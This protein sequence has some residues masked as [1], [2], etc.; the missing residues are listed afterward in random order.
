MTTINETSAMSRARDASVAWWTVAILTLAQILSFIDRMVVAI[1]VDPIRAD[2]HLSDIQIG[3]LQGLAFALFYGVMGIPLG[4]M[5]DTAN[6]R[7]LITAGIL[8][9]SVATMCCGLA[10]SFAALFIARVL[11]GVGEAS[12]SP[13]AYSM[14]SD[15]FAKER[16]SRAIGV[17]SAGSVVGGGAA[18]VVGGAVFAALE[19]AGGMTLPLVGH[20]SAWQ[21]TFV[22]VGAPGLIVAA[23]VFLSTTE[24]PR[25]GLVQDK[26]SAGLVA[27]HLTKNGAL[28]AGI[29]GCHV[30][31]AAA[32]YGL[33]NWTPTVLVRE[34]GLPAGDAGKTFGAIMLTAGLAGPVIGGW[35][36]D[37]RIRRG[38]HGGPIKLMLLGFALLAPLGLAFLFVS[39]KTLFLALLGGYVLV[40][41]A[42]VP[43]T[44]VMVQLL[45]PNRMRGQIAAINMM[46]GIIGGLGVAPVAVPVVARV[47]FGGEIQPAMAAVIAF[48]CIGGVLCALLTVGR[49]GRGAQP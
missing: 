27:A 47:A 40:C 49:A 35:L 5:A 21:A 29:F 45:A 22:A 24:P 42:L 12:L 23:I 2:L 14:F 37:H 16:L 36:S 39:G 43:L 15:L 8:L 46:I 25:S 44:H 19:R 4:R 41:T 20:L 11:V 9:W 1:L 7:V 31:L 38:D 26:S 17:Y 3:L 33:V 34:F 18:L 28:Y 13:A 10:G 32:T 48:S 6:R 30:F